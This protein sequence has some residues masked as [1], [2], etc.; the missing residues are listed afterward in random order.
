MRIFPSSFTQEF[1][2]FLSFFR[3]IFHI[4]WQLL[5]LDDKTICQKNWKEIKFYGSLSTNFKNG[6]YAHCLKITQYVAFEFMNL[7]GNTVWL[8]ASGF[9]KLDK[10][11][12][13]GIFNFDKMAFFG[14][15]N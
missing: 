6:I 13:F 10:M 11:A 14:I 8:Q 7:S 12:F 5:A 1:D 15:F 3:R 2:W 4:L 9:Q